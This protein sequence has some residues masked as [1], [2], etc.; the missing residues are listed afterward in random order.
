MGNDIEWDKQHVLKTST[1]CSCFSDSPDAKEWRP[2]I[3]P[4]LSAIFQ[5]EHFSLL[6][7]S[8]LTNALSFMAK[9]S[10]QGMGRLSLTGTY[11]DK[12]KISADK[13]ASAM[14]RGEANLEDDFRIGLEL[15]RG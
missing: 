9:I 13:S 11:K 5:S 1:E 7:G 2:K 4:W 14:E 12:V 10:A 8:G 15:L 3:E 6:V